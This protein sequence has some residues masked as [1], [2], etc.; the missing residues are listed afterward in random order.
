LRR[1]LP[2]VHDGRLTMNARFA[3]ALLAIVS[4][5]YLGFANANLIDFSLAPAG[6]FASYSEQGVTFTASG[7]GGQIL[8]TNTPNGTEGLLDNN[9]PRKELR[10]DIAGGASSVSID[11]GDFNADPD[12]LFLEIFN[13]ADVSLG[14]TSLSVDAAFDGMDTLSLSSPDIAYAIFGGRAPS[15]NGSSVF[16]DNFAWTPAA[17]VPEPASIMLL[18]L[19]LAGLGF[20]RRKQ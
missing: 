4:C 6:P 5:A 9:T 10:A 20:A 11:L 3:G 18:T 12:T 14:F 15:V 7:G 19:G 16:A 2:Y 17:A 1:A 13:A 8:G